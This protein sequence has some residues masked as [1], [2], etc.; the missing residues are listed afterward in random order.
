MVPGSVTTAKPG[1]VGETELPR[2]M[3]LY[4]QGDTTAVEHLVQKL[5]PLL[6]RF[7]SVFGASRA[8]MEDLVQECSKARKR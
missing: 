7:F 4:R 1:Y 5:S 6:Q 2:L 3:M 8:D